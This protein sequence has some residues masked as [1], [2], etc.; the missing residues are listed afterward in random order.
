MNKTL[1]LNLLK[2][3]DILSSTYKITYNK[4]HGGGYFDRGKSSIEIGVKPIKND[5]LWVFGV[6]S[7]EIM[8]VILCTMGG[9]FENGRT[10]ENYLFNFDHQIF[11]NAIQTHAQII[12]KFIYK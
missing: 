1:K 2:E 6:I 10:G 7:H 12:H 3:I 11:E 8:E 5:P 9:R 4:E